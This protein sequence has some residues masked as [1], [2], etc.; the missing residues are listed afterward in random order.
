MFWERVKKMAGHSTLQLIKLTNNLFRSRIDYQLK[1]RI[2]TKTQAEIMLFIR[3]KN[4]K[5]I[6]VNQ[7]D[8]QDNFH[9]TNPTVTGILNRL[10]EKCFIERRKS[11]KSA[12][13]NRI[14]VTDKGL[15]ELTFGHAVIESLEKE[16][17]SCL[18]ESEQKTLYDLLLKLSESNTMRG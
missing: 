15:Q 8:I 17:L 13:C 18:I 2:I 3:E 4:K 14:V 9:L 11:E 12:R 6:E 7:V 5:N 10:E 1:D 16:F